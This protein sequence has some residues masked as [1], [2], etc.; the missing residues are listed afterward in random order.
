MNLQQVKME[1][2]VLFT[3]VTLMVIGKKIYK[4]IKFKF[5]TL[6]ISVQDNVII[7]IQVI[8]IK[9]YI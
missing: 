7:L 3:Q 6:G 9:I 8:I 2:H 4:H 5:L 1:A